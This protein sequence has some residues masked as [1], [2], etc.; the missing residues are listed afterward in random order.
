MAEFPPDLLALASLD[1]REGVRRISGK[2]DAYRRQLRRFRENYG[3][4]ANHLQR[5]ASG[6][7]LRQAKDYCHLLKGIA[8]NIGATALYDQVTTIDAELK[9]EK[10]PDAS[11]LDQL[12]R[13]LHHVMRDIDTLAASPTIPPPPA[14][15]LDPEQL[16]DRLQRLS[17]ALNYDLGRAEALLA[18]LRAGGGDTPL[19]PPIAAIAARVEVFDI[20]AAQ[21]LL[22]QVQQISN[23]AT[24]ANQS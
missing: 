11:Q 4:A 15:A 2:V 21:A 9:Q 14:A 12:S 3:D 8:G 18:E 1:T 13:L 6:T 10:C 20:D 24:E 22:R 16:R 5:L 7:N 19:A 23:R 17:E